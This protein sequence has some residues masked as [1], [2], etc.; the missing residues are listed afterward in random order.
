MKFALRIAAMGANFP[1]ES[2][3]HI[4]GCV[5]AGRAPF[6]WKRGKPEIGH[7]SK[8]ALGRVHRCASGKGADSLGPQGTRKRPELDRAP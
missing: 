4:G 2:G 3:N 8:A 1:R 6:A 7:T 5:V